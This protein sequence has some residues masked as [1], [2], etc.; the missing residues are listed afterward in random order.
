MFAKENIFKIKQAFS[1]QLLLD[2]SLKN[3]YLPYSM[4]LKQALSLGYNSTIL[5][6]V[7]TNCAIEWAN[8]HAVIINEI[9]H[10]TNISPLPVC[11]ISGGNFNNNST[12][13]QLFL[14]HL[15]KSLR[16]EEDSVSMACFEFENDF[17][18]YSFT[19]NSSQNLIEKPNQIQVEKYQ[20]NYKLKSK[21]AL[22]LFLLEKTI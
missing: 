10:F 3:L 21:L 8:F 7:M 15:L 19:H 9:M 4:A 20:L 2:L 5:C 11:L 6:P 13:N 12:D 1:E 18:K 22:R 16:A 17:Y 14:F